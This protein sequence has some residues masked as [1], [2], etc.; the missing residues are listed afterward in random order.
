MTFA[1]TRGG[2]SLSSLEGHDKREKE[3][4]T[5]G[6]RHWILRHLESALSLASPKKS[7]GVARLPHWS[8]QSVLVKTCSQRH[9]CLTSWCFQRGLRLVNSRNN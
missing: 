9:Q 3:E 5:G 7:G 1:A 6:D 8:A 2:I 4:R